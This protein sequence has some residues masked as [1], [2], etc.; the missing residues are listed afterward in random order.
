MGRPPAKGKIIERKSGKAARRT[1]VAFPPADWSR[2]RRHAE[3]EGRLVT[4]IVVTAVRRY[5]DELEGK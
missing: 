1:T 2:L 5:L 3:R 4:W